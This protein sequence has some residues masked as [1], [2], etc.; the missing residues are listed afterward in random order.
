MASS[1]SDLVNNFSERVHSIKCKFGHDDKKCEI[2]EIKYNYFECFR[3]CINFKNDLI[4]QKCLCFDKN[5]Q[6]KFDEKLKERFFN[7]YKVS[8]HDNNNI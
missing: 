4:E 3:E 5:Y 2:C 1:L 7:A 6:R 8:N